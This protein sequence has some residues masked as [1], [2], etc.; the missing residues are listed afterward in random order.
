MKMN[1]RTRV[2]VDE[3]GSRVDTFELVLCDYDLNVDYHLP[4]RQFLVGALNV[5]VNGIK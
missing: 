4:L 2:G 5:N 1:P 3:P